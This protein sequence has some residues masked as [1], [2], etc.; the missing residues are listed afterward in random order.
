MRYL[1]TIIVIAVLGLGVWL[2]ADT[3][4]SVPADDPATTT[5]ATTTD[6]DASNDQRPVSYTP[7]EAQELI[8]V[9][10]P[11]Q[12]EGISSPLTIT[13]EARGQWFFEATAPVVLTDWDG[14]IIAEGYVQAEGDW[15]TEDFVPFSG[16]LEFTAPTEDD[17]GILIIQRANASGLAENDMAVEIPVQFSQ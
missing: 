17:R 16:T 6:A 2:L 13:G 5:P 3:T 4:G 9:T 1:L 14:R 12:E 7:D 8:S 11:A 15:M 10:D